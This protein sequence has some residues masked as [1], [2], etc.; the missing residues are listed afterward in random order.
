MAQTKNIFTADNG[1]FYLKHGRAAAGT[2]NVGDVIALGVDDGVYKVLTGS[3]NMSAAGICYTQATCVV[4]TDEVQFIVGVVGPLSCSTSAPPT[5]KDVGKV[6]YA[7]AFGTGLTLTK[8]ASTNPLVG[9]VFSVDPVSGDA[10]V[11]IDTHLFPS[12]T[13]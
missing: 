4:A 5:V 12:G 13:L 8:T 3:Q 2:Y 7:S 10:Q 6:V 9:R 11:H 1:L